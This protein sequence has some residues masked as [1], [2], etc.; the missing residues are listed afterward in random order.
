VSGRDDRDG[1]EPLPQ[2]L[3]GERIAVSGHACP[4][5]SI[6][7]VPAFC[8][9]CLGSGVVTTERLARWQRD[10]DRLIAEM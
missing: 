10:Q 8:P 2:H 4:E 1:R 9:V 6:A 5:H 3:R 7:Y